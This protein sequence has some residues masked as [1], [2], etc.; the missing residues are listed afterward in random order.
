MASEMIGHDFYRHA[1][2]HGIVARANY[3]PEI[4]DFVLRA[5]KRHLGGVPERGLEMC[6][7]AAMLS[8]D[9]QS[10]GV[11]MMAVD[12]QPEMVQYAEDYCKQPGVEFTVGD[13]CK[14][15][16][17][18]PVDFVTNVGNNL[19]VLRTNELLVEMLRTTA[20]NIRPG[21][22]FVVELAREW[23][24]STGVQ[25]GVSPP[26]LVYEQSVAPRQTGEEDGIKVTVDWC[27]GDY[28]R[29]DPLSQLFQHDLVLTIETE[30]GV[31]QITSLETGKIHFTQEFL[32]AAQLAGG[33]EPIGFYSDFRI[34]A[35]CRRDPST[36]EY[37]ALFRRVD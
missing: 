13:M 29:L 26:W 4:A 37:V 3:R 27:G 30:E 23:V 1:H 34:T 12:L 25:V 17:D 24:M 2:Y 5:Y 21:G 15:R 32:L 18:E 22:L 20:A 28:T 7:G 31:E 19:A 10:R 16:L 35:D 33:L 14:F 6:C 9:L 36:P 8:A 11:S